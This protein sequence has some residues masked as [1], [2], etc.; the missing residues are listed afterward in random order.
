M[1]EKMV[2]VVRARILVATSRE[3]VET[4]HRA[5]AAARRACERFSALTAQL[6]RE[7]SVFAPA[8]V[9]TPPS[10]PNKLSTAPRHTGR[11]ARPGRRL[12]D[13]RASP[14]EKRRVLLVSTDERWRLLT[15][16]LFAEVG[17]VA[18]ATADCVQALERTVTLLPD[19]VVADTTGGDA[20]ALLQRLAL[21]SR[22]SDIPVVMLMSSLHS[23]EAERA[24]AAGAATILP[25][26]GEIDVLV[27]EV[28]T[29]VAVAPRARRVI[30]RRLLELQ[31]LARH[32]T[33]DAEGRAALGCLIDRLQ[34]AIVALDVRGQCLAASHGAVRLTG[35]SRPEML[36]AV[37]QSTFDGGHLSDADWEEFLERREYVGIATITTQG[38]EQVTVHAAVLAGVMPGVHVAALAAA[39]PDA[40]LGR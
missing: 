17:Y 28:D 34:V 7:R 3:L 27:G 22:T 20:I 5:H 30:R 12:N 32:Y 8:A 14:A 19:V 11:R 38:G 40:S 39:T 26:A 29:L 15:A 24:R 21:S 25:H 31:E 2:A 37:F 4:S 1:S 9:L 13:Q 35:Y 18:Y 23:V 36:K 16:Y 33:P 6:A 10:A